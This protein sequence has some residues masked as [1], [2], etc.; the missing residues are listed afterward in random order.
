MTQHYLETERLILRRWRSEDVAP[1]AA[2]C[3]DPDVM[4]FIGDGSTR[5]AGE[6][7]SLVAKLERFWEARNYGLFA[8]E[9]RETNEFLGFAGLSD[10]DFMP[11]L[12]PSV[13]IGWRLGKAHWGK[14]YATEAATA[15]LAF[16]IES[17][18][19]EEIVSI[20]QVGNGASTSIM[21]KIG[22]EFDRR[23]LDP[24]CDREVFVYRL[25]RK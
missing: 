3:A 9:L 10:P 12:L 4:E 17:P 13:E 20:C 6:T 14:G 22:L 1:F 21:K 18:D 7:V 19:I 5:T 24:T 16:A 25:P 8:I 11:E 15:A 23:S 2:I